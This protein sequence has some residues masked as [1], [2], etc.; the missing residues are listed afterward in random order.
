MATVELDA[1]FLAL[2]LGEVRGAALDRARRAR[3][4]A[5]R[6]SHR[7]NPLAGSEPA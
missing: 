2:P 6:G 3:L 1:E 4:R 5:R 7:A